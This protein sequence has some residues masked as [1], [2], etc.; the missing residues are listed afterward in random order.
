MQP[1]EARRVGTLCSLSGWAYN[2]KIR[3]G[4]HP[5]IRAGA[6]IARLPRWCRPQKRMAFSTVATH[7]QVMRIDVLADG[8][9]RWVAGKR[10]RYVTLSGIEFGVAPWIVRKFS[11]ALG[12]VRQC[13]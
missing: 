12:K 3:R 7:G 8:S 4:R 1:I 13:K 2:P 9:V 6:D 5:G 11:K 10:N